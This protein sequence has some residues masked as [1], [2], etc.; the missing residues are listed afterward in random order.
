MPLAMRLTTALLVAL[1]PAVVSARDTM[2]EDS[3]M[4]RKIYDAALVD[5]P[6]YG[7]LTELVEKFPGRLSGSENLA[8]AVRWARAEL[9]KLGCDRIE[10]QPVMVPHWERGAPESARLRPSHPSPDSPATLAL[11]ALGN[12]AATPPDGVVAPVVEVQSIEQLAQL[13]RDQVA[14]RIVFF[15]R[16]LDP[17]VISGTAAYRGAVDQ[18]TRGPAAAARLGAV[19][20]LVRSMTHARDDIPHT[21]NTTFPPGVPAVPAAALGVRSAEL[22][23]RQLAED[24]SLQV[25]LRIHA[26]TLPDAPSHNVIGEVRGREAPEKIIL[27]AGHLDSWDISPGAHDDGA[28][29]VQSLEVLRLFKAIGYTPRHT[30]RVV[31]FTNEE[32]GIRGALEYARAVGD[33]REE[34]LLALESDSGG[35]QPHGF[36]LGNAAGDAH[37]RAERWLPLFQ[38]Y[39]IT[40]FRE[41]TGG[42][43]VAPLLRF[44]YTVAG[45]TPDS[46]RYFDY[47][48]TALDNIGQVNPRELAL[49]AAAMAALVY[50]VDRHGP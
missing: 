18:R 48:H 6:M 41:G 50:L 4:L 24:P 13:G 29:C 11:L 31:L 37:R 20:V 8:G 28:G 17:R 7:Q 33:R 26:R 3:A 12:S 10:L 2:A 32:N 45:L 46:Q 23:S 34:H 27:V 14:G 30:I 43:D 35:Y 40:W 19:A 16:P 36:N 38:P 5:S 44:G 39:G 9:E 21:G 22:L 25:E 15:N 49:G 1:L 47:H 42:V